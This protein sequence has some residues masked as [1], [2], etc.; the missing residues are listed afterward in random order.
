MLRHINTGTKKRVGE[1]R[2]KSNDTNKNLVLCNVIFNST[3]R[4]KFG[5]SVTKKLKDEGR[6]QFLNFVF[7]VCKRVLFKSKNEKIQNKKDIQNIF[8]EF[9]KNGGKK[10]KE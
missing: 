5:H 10:M 3:C 4:T 6:D 2:K 7:P 9:T 1:G 8:L